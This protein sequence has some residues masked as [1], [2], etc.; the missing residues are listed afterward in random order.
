MC[1]YLSRKICVAALANSL[2]S[3]HQDAAWSNQALILRFIRTF[4]SECD[5]SRWLRSG[6]QQILSVNKVWS[7]RL[8]EDWYSLEVFPRLVEAMGIDVSGMDWLS[9]H[10]ELL[11][12]HRQRAAAASSSQ[13]ASL[14]ALPLQPLSSQ[15]VSLVALPLQ[16][17]HADDDVE[18]MSISALREEVRC[19]RTHLTHFSSSQKRTYKKTE[20][21]EQNHGQS[22][23][24][25]GQSHVQII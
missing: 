24:A 25:E 2:Y 18:S 8:G 6:G 22:R 9:I 7:C 23:K 3:L 15:A 10:S 4:S 20:G 12:A 11:D 21:I 16:P 14:V 5:V 19:L 17:G 1:A 13:A